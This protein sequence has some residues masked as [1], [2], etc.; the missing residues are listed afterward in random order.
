MTPIDRRHVL[1][2]LF[3]ASLPTPTYA[4]PLPLIALPGDV[5]A[6]D[7][8][9][10]ELSGTACRLSDY[11]GRPVLVS[12]W[13]VWCPPCRRELAAL[14]DLHRRLADTPIALLA[15]NLGDSLERITAF[16]ADH[17]APGLTVLLDASKSTA[18]PWHVRGLPLAYAVGPD[19]TLRLG[20]LGE[21]DWRSA[22]IER[23]LRALV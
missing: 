7:L 22:A 10:P 23:Q 20:A 15:V 18:A 6:P 13:A 9:L 2:L 3:S 12:F 1:A 4:D 11:R 14:A 21:R 19:G 16:L 5:P 17:P 8:D